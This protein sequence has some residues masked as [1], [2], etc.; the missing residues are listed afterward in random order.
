MVV[1]H[2]FGADSSCWAPMLTSLASSLQGIDTLEVGQRI[3]FPVWGLRWTQ[4]SVSRKWQFKNG[5]SIFKLVMDLHRNRV[6]P[7]GLTEREPLRV[8]ARQG[9]DGWGL[10]SNDNRRL[11]ALLMYQ[12]C[13]GQEHARASASH[14]LCVIVF[15]HL[16]RLHW[17]GTR[18]TI[19]MACI[20]RHRAR[21]SSS[22]S[23]GRN[24]LVHLHRM[25]CGGSRG[26][27]ALGEYVG[28]C[29]STEDLADPP[30]FWMT[31]S[32][33]G[34]LRTYLEQTPLASRMLMPRMPGV[35]QRR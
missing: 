6:T 32:T 34:M 24:A 21:V 3:K 8:Y 28:S 11:V 10:Y 15:V 29:G 23:L 12:A 26:G 18:S 30:L 4:T 13:R 31:G 14:A 16:P 25:H 1:E 35:L 9:P 27:G 5:S 22:P 19:C 7:E 20:V 17:A 33:F 2:T